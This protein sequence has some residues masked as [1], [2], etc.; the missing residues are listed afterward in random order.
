MKLP[1]TVQKNLLVLLV[2]SLLLLPGVS[3]ALNPRGQASDE[4]VGGL[5][6]AV[7][8]DPDENAHGNPRKPLLS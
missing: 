6:I 5:Q 7:F 4:T 8:P 3:A 1:K 2:A